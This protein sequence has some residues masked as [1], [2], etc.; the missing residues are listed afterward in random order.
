MNDWE[1]P[2]IEELQDVIM[3]LLVSISFLTIERDE[4]KL[5]IMKIKKGEHMPKTILKKAVATKK[6][7]KKKTV[8]TTTKK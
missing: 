5:K 6:A 8:K 2:T 1:Y 3:E 7:A 4:L